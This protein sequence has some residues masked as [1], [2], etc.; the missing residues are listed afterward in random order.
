MLVVA[1]RT[2]VLLLAVLIY[3]LL[4]TYQF[5]DSE[6]LVAYTMLLLGYLAAE[7]WNLRK[8]DRRWHWLNPVVLASLFTFALSFGASN[9]L[10]F[11]PDDVVGLV[12]L[13]PLATP[14]MNQLML[15]VVLAAIAMWSGYDSW[16]GIELGRMVQKSRFL[17]QWITPSTQVNRPIIYMCITVSLGARFLMISLGVYG[18]S[19]D[20]GQLIG[21]AGYTQYLSIAESL[22]QL[23]LLGVAIHCFAST[24]ASLFDRQLLIL[25]LGYEVAFGFLSGFKSQVFMPFIVVGLAYYSQRQRFPRWMI[26]AVLVALIAAY[27]VI[28]PFREARYHDASFDSTDVGSIASTMATA[29]DDKGDGEERA[30]TALSVLA[31]INMTYVASRGIEYAA[32]TKLPEDSP[33]FLGDILLAPVHAIVPR[34]LWEGKPFQNIGL[35]YTVEVMGYGLEDGILSSTAMGPVTYLNFAGGSLAVVVGFF[36]VG[37][38]QRVLFDGL[39]SFGGGGLIVFFGLLRIL[40]LIDSAYNTLFVSLIRLLPL[41][42]FAQYVLLIRPRSLID[43][44]KEPSHA[45][46]VDFPHAGPV[47][48]PVHL[49]G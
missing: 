8:Y 26:P 30:G 1:M 7:A 20:Y 17:R 41:L 38:L 49:R 21:V 48:D 25:V 22:G 42:L 44:S 35:W 43:K 5:T 23:A 27:A 18:F 10:F 3:A 4:T 45:P 24:R 15:L 16:M 28:E 9:A 19:S 29:G 12:G 14:W 33:N 40:V 13:E 39:R 36:V 37:V 11:L 6:G 31:R 32:T 46:R 2:M 47:L 34:I